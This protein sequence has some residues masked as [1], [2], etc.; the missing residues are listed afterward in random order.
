MLVFVVLLMFNLILVFLFSLFSFLFFLLLFL[1]SL[2]LS[3]FY[4]FFPTP[5]FFLPGHALYEINFE[6]K[7]QTNLGT[8]FTRPVKRVPRGE[9]EEGGREG[10]GREGGEKWYWWHNRGWAEFSGDVEENLKEAKRSGQPKVMFRAGYFFVVFVVLILFLLFV[11]VN[12]HAPFSLPSPFI[13][14]LHY[15]HTHTHTLGHATYVVNLI[16]M[17]Q[18]NLRTRFARDVKVVEREGGGEGEGERERERERE[19]EG[20]REGEEMGRNPFLTWE[21]HGDQVSLSI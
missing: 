18:T 4:L 2:P 20:E 9:R 19:E 11:I 3:P 12:S 13:E 6:R 5:I 10:R 8:K 1:T 16:T 21:F 15:T 17:K 7:V 14:C